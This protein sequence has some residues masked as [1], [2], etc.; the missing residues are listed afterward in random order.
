MPVSLGITYTNTHDYLAWIV[1]ISLHV[2]LSYQILSSLRVNH[3][4]RSIFYPVPPLDRQQPVTKS[5][6]SLLNESNTENLSLFLDLF[7][8]MIHIILAYTLIQAHLV[9]L[10]FTDT[11]FFYKLKFCGNPASRRSIST[12]FQQ[13]LL[14]SCH[15]F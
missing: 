8:R 9:S 11:A 5:L 2:F 4:L 6:L 10:H 12:I 7:L 14:T 3:L 15:N 1:I 13:H